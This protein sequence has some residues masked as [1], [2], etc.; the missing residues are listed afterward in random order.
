VKFSSLDAREIGFE[1]SV[2]ED[3]CRGVDIK[4]G[5]IN[6]ALTEMQNHGAHVITSADV[7]IQ[8]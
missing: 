1:V 3:A 5:D 4:P 6:R 8:A 7:L 2:I